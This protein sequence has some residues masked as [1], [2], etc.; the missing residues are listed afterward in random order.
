[1]ALVDRRPLLAPE[2]ALVHDLVAD[3]STVLRRARQ[4]PPILWT[5]PRSRGSGLLARWCFLPRPTAGVHFLVRY[6]VYRS[7]DRLLRRFAERAALEGLD[8]DARRART[9]LQEFQRS[10]PPVRLRWLVLGVVVA[11]VMLGRAL[12]AQVADVIPHVVLRPDGA[13]GLSEAQAA[14]VRSVLDGMVTF[15]STL[16]GSSLHDLTDQLTR[17]DARALLALAGSLAVAG[18]CVLR[19]LATSFRVKRM[20]FNLVDEP[21]EALRYTASTWHVPRATGLYDR[22]RRTLQGLGVDPPSEIPLDLGLSLLITLLVAWPLAAI[23]AVDT[24]LLVPDRVGFAV[25]IAFFAGLR[26]LW[27]AAVFRSRSAPASPVAPSAA[28]LLPAT[29]RVVEV[30]SP[31]QTA[32]LATVPYLTPPTIYRLGRELHHLRKERALQS[33]RAAHGSVPAPVTVVAALGWAVLWPAVAANRM[34]LAA[35]TAPI[36]R[37][38]PLLVSGGLVLVVGTSAW[39]VFAMSPIGSSAESMGFFL[40]VIGAGLTGAC[41]QALQNRAV[42]HWA[43]ASWPRHGAP[44]G[45]APPAVFNPPPGWPPP[46]PGWSPAPGWRPDS[47]WPPVPAEWRCW[48][49]AEDASPGPVGTPVPVPRSSG[50]RRP[51]RV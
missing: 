45:S 32:A 36:S 22:E 35:R 11:T 33:L 44:A 9:V 23:Y 41:L 42:R 25:V 21:D 28:L 13:P 29:G 51:V 8:R 26:V 50:D 6:H 46:P 47:T 1:M 40:A 2:S 30:S 27:L 31:W 14:T 18:Y 4:L 7:T 38:D 43:V 3:Y 24:T 12:V 48:V 37:H 20:V 17:A 10:L 49:P 34:I 16:S 15:S 19:P 39:V 5:R